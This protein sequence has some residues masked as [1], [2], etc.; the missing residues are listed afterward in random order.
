M[1]DPHSAIG[2]QDATAIEGVDID[3]DDDLDLVLAL[4]GKKPTLR[5]NPGLATS[6]IAPTGTPTAKEGVTFP[7][8]ETLPAAGATDVALADTCGDAGTDITPAQTSCSPTSWASRSSWHQPP[9]RKATGRPQ[10]QRPRRR[11]PHPPSIR[12]VRGRGQ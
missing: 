8:D 6:G 2:A 4:D 7:L 12:Q 10:A 5:L 11:W 1:A 3:D 9:L